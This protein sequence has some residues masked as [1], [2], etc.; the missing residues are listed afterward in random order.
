MI[1]KSVLNLNSQLGLCTTVLLVFWCSSIGFCQQPPRIPAQG[2]SPLRPPSGG[3]WGKLSSGLHSRNVVLFWTT[4][5]LNRSDWVPVPCCSSINKMG[6]R[7]ASPPGCP[8]REGNPQEKVTPSRRCC[9]QYVF[10]DGVP[11]LCA[12]SPGPLPGAALNISSL[13]LSSFLPSSSSFLSIFSS[14][15]LLHL[16]CL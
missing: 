6:V 14:V 4:G 13:V 7:A 8:A 11:E 16:L 12:R 1:F 2:G 15:V 5:L 3:P 9:S 10:V